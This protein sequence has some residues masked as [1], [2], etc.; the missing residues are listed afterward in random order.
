MNQLTQ[1]FITWK[2]VI[3]RGFL[4]STVSMATAVVSGLQDYKTL[5]DL[6]ALTWIKICA[7][8]IIAGG[9]NLGGFLDSSFTRKKDE[10]KIPVKL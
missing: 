9:T 10:L 7:A 3:F 8:A 4:Y 5:S 2:M 6:D 1:G